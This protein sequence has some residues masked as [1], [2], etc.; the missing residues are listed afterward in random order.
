MVMRV[1]W[2]NIF[3]IRSLHDKIARYLYENHA[4]GFASHGLPP[5]P[6]NPSDTDVHGILRPEQVI[7][8]TYITYCKFLTYFLS[9]K[10]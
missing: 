3:N 1:L 5:L 7:L 8:I 2:E 10:N 4:D 9:R 6:E